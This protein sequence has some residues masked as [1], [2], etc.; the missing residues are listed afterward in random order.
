MLEQIYPVYDANSYGNVCLGKVLFP[1]TLVSRNPIFI[2]I[3]GNQ[4]Q[5]TNRLKSVSGFITDL[6]EVESIVDFVGK[7]TAVNDLHAQSRTLCN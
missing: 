5:I 7:Y 4:T 2:D 3:Q 6:I 1:D